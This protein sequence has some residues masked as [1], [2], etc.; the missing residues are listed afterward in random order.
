MERQEQIDEYVED[1]LEKGMNPKELAARLEAKGWPAS[2]VIAT[3]L[4]RLRRE[5]ISYFSAGALSGIGFAMI[6]K[7]VMGF[8]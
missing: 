6:I 8:A 3:I 2:I 5:R 4:P 7:G 1:R